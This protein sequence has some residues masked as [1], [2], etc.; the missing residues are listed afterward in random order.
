MLPPPT[1]YPLHTKSYCVVKISPT[2]SPFNN[3]SSCSG[4]GALNGLW[5]NVQPLLL[6]CISATSA[7][8]TFLKNGKL[9]T[10]ANASTPSFFS[11]S[12]RKSNLSAPNFL[13]ASSYEKTGNCS[14]W[15]LPPTALTEFFTSS[16]TVSITS[17]RSTKLISKSSCVNSKPRSARKSSSR[18]QRANWK[19]FSTPA[20]I[21][22]CLYCCGLCG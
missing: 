6:S 5:V 8:S 17:S 9:M 14:F 7:T 10:H 20:V 15:S 3:H 18:M 22:N 11:C 1:S 12:L 13:I 16:S 19:Y 21:N 4:I 2:F